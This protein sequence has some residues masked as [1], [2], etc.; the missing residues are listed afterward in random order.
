MAASVCSLD[1]A[2]GMEEPLPPPL[3]RL[4][5]ASTVA[6]HAAWQRVVAASA[7]RAP[8]MPPSR[9]S[10]RVRSGGPCAKCRRDCAAEELPPLPER[11]RRRTAWQGREAEE[12]RME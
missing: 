6:V 2:R 10:S 7:R 1:P 8:L 9:L 12:Q 3:L 11:R 4:A 5:M